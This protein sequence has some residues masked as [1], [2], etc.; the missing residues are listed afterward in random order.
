MNKRKRKRKPGQ[1]VGIT[2]EKSVTYP[3]FYRYAISYATPTLLSLLILQNNQRK[4]ELGTHKSTRSAVNL[5]H[6]NDKKS[7]R[8][9]THK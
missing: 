5:K 4:I 6:K 2:K 7:A 8:G 3:V 9:S 1:F